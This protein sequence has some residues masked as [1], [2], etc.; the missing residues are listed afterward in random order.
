M[1]CVYPHRFPCMMIDGNDASAVSTAKVDPGKSAPSDFVLQ[2]QGMNEGTK[3]TSY[4]HLF[5]GTDPH[6]L[7]DKTRS[8]SKG[9]ETVL[10]QPIIGKGASSISRQVEE[11]EASRTIKLEDLAKLVSSVQ[12]SFKDLDS[13]D[14]DPIIVV[15]DSNKDEEANK[16]HATTNVETED[17]LVPKSS[18][19]S[20]LPTELKELPSKFNELTE[21][22]KGLKKQVHNLKIKLLGELKEIPTKLENFTKTVT[23]LTSQAIASKKTKDNSVPSTGQA[24]TQPAEEEKNTIQATISYSSQPEG[25]H[26]KKNKGKKALSSEKAE[27]VSTNIDSNDDET[28]MTGSMVESFRIKK[29]KKFDFVTEDGKHIHLTKEQINQQKKIEEE[30]KAKAAKHECEVRKGELVDLFSPEV[31]K[32]YYNDKL[33]YDCRILEIITQSND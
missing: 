16:V 24:G 33:Q 4:D 20:S 9:L 2:Q 13:H 10:T 25:E 3:N 22:G 21:E 28:H 7:V 30:A 27:K 12:P 1:A 14:D 29:V 11:D 15:D 5:T 6:V 26:I 31:V 32:K 23:S 8:V 17:T 19:F 18:S